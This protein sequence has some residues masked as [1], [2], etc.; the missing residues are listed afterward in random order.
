MA[1]LDH[2]NIEDAQ[3]KTKDLQAALQQASHDI[4]A[5]LLKFEETTGKAIEQVDV[6][7]DATEPFVVTLLL[8]G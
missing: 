7:C 4:R 6:D 5:V 1:S 3:V 8:G 2:F